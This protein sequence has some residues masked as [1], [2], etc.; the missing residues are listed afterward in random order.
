[1]PGLARRAM[2]SK[3]SA[4]RDLPLDPLLAS[5][6]LYH[7][8]AAPPR[9]GSDALPAAERPVERGGVLEPE[10]ARDLRYV[11]MRV[12]EKFAAQ[13]LSR[14][15]DQGAKAAPSSVIRRCKVRSL[16]PRSRATAEASGRPLAKPR[17]STA[18]TC[19]ENELRGLRRPKLSSSAGVMTSI[20]SAL[21][22]GN[23]R[24]RSDAFNTSVSRPF[25]VKIGH[26]KKLS[27]PAV[28]APLRVSSSRSGVSLW[29]V[30]R[31]PSDSRNA[32]L[33]STDR[34]GSNAAA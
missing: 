17:I 13:L 3:E 23:G 28:G 29:P 8:V 21:C 9:L 33:T 25:P 34:F 30:P 19:S 16:V 4:T 31:R 20:N 1:M 11:S 7:G 32:K 2:A 27:C 24:S 14:L 12:G 18:L 26:P 15:L 5:A 10:D 22:P 6:W